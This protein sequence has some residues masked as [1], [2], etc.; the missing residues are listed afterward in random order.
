MRES[1]LDTMISVPI[2]GPSQPYKD[3]A[4]MEFTLIDALP[5]IA[6]LDSLIHAR[7][8]NSAT[9]KLFNA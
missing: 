6:Q 5:R 3:S 1:A 9:P 7:S 4:P 2:L 8:Y